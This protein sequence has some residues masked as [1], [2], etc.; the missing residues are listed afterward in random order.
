MS[1]A[2]K[3]KILLINVSTLPNGKKVVH[4]YLKRKSKGTGKQTTGKLTLKKYNPV[5]RKHVEYT[6]SKYK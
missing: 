2:I 1:Q 4:R 6:E 5:L 3:N